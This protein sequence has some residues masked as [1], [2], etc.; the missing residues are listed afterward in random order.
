MRRIGDVLVSRR[1]EGVGYIAPAVAGS[2][3]AGGESR[4]SS[5]GR[6]MANT[7]ASRS[8]RDWN[9]GV[10]MVVQLEPGWWSAEILLSTRKWGRAPQLCAVV[11]PGEFGRRGSQGEAIRA[12]AG[13]MMR[14]LP[15]Q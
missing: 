8:R 12:G 1:G 2:N 4:C 3:P 11:P 6:A 5:I 7:W 10:V 15:V 14:S 13:G 9:S